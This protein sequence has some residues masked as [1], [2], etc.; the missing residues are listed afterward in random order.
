MTTYTIDPSERKAA[1]ITR[2]LRY[3]AALLGDLRVAFRS[4]ARTPA[5][6]AT[7]ALTLA[8]GIGANAAIFSV[9][10]G[11]LLRPLVN[12]D[13]DRLIYVQQS[14]PGM[15]GGSSVALSLSI[16]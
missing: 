10:R 11:V 16:R 6:W 3:A 5:L 14:A 1:E 7:V 2:P 12:R 4:L 9:M 15:Q 8:L 13:E